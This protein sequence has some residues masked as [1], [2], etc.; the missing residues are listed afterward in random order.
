[1]RIIPAFM[2]L[3]VCS[4]VI[5][6]Q[7]I[8]ISLDTL[9]AFPDDSITIPVYASNLNNAG[10]FTFFINYPGTSLH[11]GRALNWNSALLPGVH[12]ANASGNQL[13]I[14]WADQN[15]TSIIQGKLLD[16]R[17]KYTGGSGNLAFNTTSS[18]ITD[19]W[20]SP[21]LQPVIFNNGYF[22][23]RLSV[24]VT[25]NPASLCFGDS[26]Q[27]S[28]TTQGGMGN[29]QYSW[30]S[31]PAGFS[32][33]FLTPW[34][35]PSVSTYY[36]IMVTDGHDTA[37]GNTLVPVFFFQTPSP[38]DNMLP[39][40]G[41]TDLSLPVLFTWSPAGSA[42]GY[43]L[44]IWQDGTEEPSVPL[45]SNISQISYLIT[46]FLEYGKTYHW[47]IIAK[48]PC[49]SMPG[50]IQTFSVRQLPDLVVTGVFPPSQAYSGQTINVEFQVKNIGQ[51]STLTQQWTDMVYLSTDTTLETDVDHYIGAY[52]NLT[53]LNPQEAYN[54]NI[55]FT[56]PQG[57]SGYYYI[58][59]YS[60]YY[61][62][63]TESNNNNNKRFNTSNFLVY[64]SPVPDLQVNRI[65]VQNSAFSGQ[66]INLTW[67]VKNTGLAS[68]GVSEWQDRVYFSSDTTLLPSAVNLG[69]FPHSGTLA[70]DS[71]YEQTRLITLPAY[72]SG[73][74]YLFVATDVYNQ[75]YEHALE[76]NNTLR[77]DSI[78]IFLTPPPDL[79][80]TAV[81]APVS[82][83][84]VETVTLQWTVQNQ[85]VNAASGH[86][87]DKI[88]LTNSLTLNT[89]TAFYLGGSTHYGP[90]DPDSS[91]TV[92][93]EVI[94]PD[95]LTGNY[96][97]FVFS[98]A[99]LQIF[100]NN[101]EENNIRRC[102]HPTE[103]LGADLFV[104]NIV[105][106]DTNFSGQNLI[107][108]YSS[109]N[110]GNGKLTGSWT[111][112]FYLSVLPYFRED[113]SILLGFKTTTY[114]GIL[115]GDSLPQ[116]K[117]LTVP[118]GLNGNYYLYIVSDV[119]NTIF[120]P[121][122]ENN[123]ISR[124]AEPFRINLTPWPDL[125]VTACSISQDTI[126]A[127]IPFEITYTLKN[128]GPGP[129]NGALTREGFY[130]SIQTVNLTIY[131]YFTY[132]RDTLSLLPDSSVTKTV[133]ISFPGYATSANYY[134]WVRADN[135]NFIYE[136][137]GEGNNNSSA[138]PVFMKPY[139]PIDLAA[140]S[141]NTVESC[142]SGTKIAIDWTAQNLGTV[143]T[144]SYG[145]YDALYLTTDTIPN[146]ASDIYLGRVFHNGSVP[147]GQLYSSGSN[148]LI[149]NGMQGDFHLYV[150]IDV[151]NYNL[152][153][154]IANNFLFF[155]G[156]GG[157]LKI[158]HINLTPPP[159]LVFANFSCPEYGTTGQPITLTWK[160]KNQGVGITPDY[161]WV[162]K[163][164][165]ST[166]FIADNQG[167]AL[168]AT[169]VHPATLP[170]DSEYT[171][172]REVFLPI[173]AAGNYIVLVVTDAT[174]IIYEGTNE[175][176]N[177]ASQT[178]LIQQP[179]PCDLVVSQIIPPGAAVA[180]ENLSLTWT[181]MNQ[182]TNPA[183][184]TMKD[185]VYFSRDTAWDINDI[186]FGS[187]NG[188]IS[189]G[190][191][192]NVNRSV[193]ATLTGVAPGQW[194]II[195]RTDVLNNIY[196]GNDNNNTSYAV[197]TLQVTVP[198]LPLNTWIVHALTNYS[199][200]YYR[201][202]IPLG[203]A[204]ETMLVNLAGDS[205]F[206]SNE[207]YLRFSDLPSRTSYDYAYSFPNSGNQE[208]ILPSLQAGTYY[209]MAYGSTTGGTIQ[210]IRLKARILNFQVLSVD[211][212]QGGNTG[213]VTLKIT[214]SKFVPAMEVF[215]IRGETKIKGTNLLF[216]DA[217]RVYASFDLSGADTGTY[218]VMAGKFCQGYAVLENGFSIV[219]GGIPDLQV[220]VYQP[221]SVRPLGIATI[222]IE[223][224]NNG[225]TDLVAP[226]GELT[227][228][229]NAPLS[230]TVTGL[231]QNLTSLVIPFREPG[232][233]PD[234][235]RPGMSG[236]I[237][238]YARA[239]SGLAIMMK[240][241]NY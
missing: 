101:Q 2:I 104:S 201:I 150:R 92:Q 118:D 103:I 43:D 238:V 48:N 49:L 145:W 146:P 114:A 80:T 107:V 77:S 6:A 180:G 53:Y 16:L 193:S 132:C 84:N 99:N 221:S 214:G 168:L 222:V 13:G 70:P 149:P 38:V 175:N 195:V 25:A 170:V 61:N 76:N 156:P 125:V 151:Y 152:D 164:F 228:V 65:I 81:I 162:D 89:S 87:F 122:H 73:R 161:N 142:F 29:L 200:L 197:Q 187:L 7:T 130:L 179:P 190:P 3:L 88:Y 20:G 112:R 194:Y 129:V 205:I 154:N 83:S 106:P 167:D 33:S 208:V 109:R 229:A 237:T 223:F 140:L 158:L 30:S 97:F 186:Y 72:I 176:N 165:L 232:G 59:V 212:A 95:Q 108:S 75:V 113:S 40:D 147:P 148:T 58:L 178:L 41:S 115:P 123:N 74:Y 121:L 68:T 52:S 85:G 204:G 209:L 133:V 21:V 191:Q 218:Q 4:L 155:K 215:L 56:L 69:T 198:E 15:G 79:V 27:L 37:Y 230:F 235:L 138:I 181:I 42:T 141:L 134:L 90:L 57:I 5:R 137:T 67:L 82:V 135:D 36:N 131:N 19:I 185:M 184:G 143:T 160:I 231:N 171:V 219:D 14:V 62:N 10:S 1:M 12:L 28:F 166:D 216:I 105:T 226:N 78:T 177:L 116:S 22:T 234:I 96:Y 240:L 11:W 120:E 9:T 227:S 128:T 139:P 100:E 157:Q 47:K 24:T 127:G 8:T 32:S 169:I 126:T 51:G 64:L 17:F 18:E 45:I 119:F 192:A 117:T 199:P 66:Q 63:L 110:T 172:T 124:R 136:H 239:S 60:D 35:T 34:T 102:S 220:V 206:G 211:A 159:D 93:K 233:P 46:T 207:L 55:S 91:Y 202:E 210:N 86:W 44:V 26:T 217:S 144:Y 31:N 225:N 98:D 111:D 174:D 173:W 241:P 50:P 54:Q 203:L 153:P 163:I 182:G 196:E 188:Y 224:T 94:V 71:V 236:T 189:L 213:S 39:S 183:V 23:R